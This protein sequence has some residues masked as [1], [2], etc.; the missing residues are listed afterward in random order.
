MTL[1]DYADPEVVVGGELVSGGWL[2]GESAIHFVGRDEGSGLRQIEVRING[3][4][5]GVESLG[6]CEGLI[7]GTD[8]AGSVRPCEPEIPAAEFRLS[9]AAGPFHEGSNLVDVCGLDFAGNE[10]CRS[11]QVL[12][13]NVAPSLS[14]TAAQDSEDPE[15]I[16]AVVADQHSGVSTGE[17]AYRREGGTLWQPLE[18]T[19]QGGALRARVDSTASPPATYE[20]RAIATDLAGNRAETTR[21]TDGLEM[22]LTFPL[23]KG[24]DLNAAI[25]P[26]GAERVT[27]PYGKRSRVSGVLR[28]IAGGPIP[29]Q[30]VV[31]REYFGEGALIRD[32][33][34]TVQTDSRGR[35]TSKLPAGPSRRVTAHYAG[36]QRYLSGTSLGGQLAVRTKAS[37]RTSKSRVPEGGRVIFRGKLGRLGARIPPGGKLL[38]LQ[39]KQDKHTYQTVGQG[40]RSSPSG[41][42]RVPYRFGRFYQYDVRFKFRVKVAREADWPYKAPVRSRGRT[43]T[44]LDR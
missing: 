8:L 34:T 25:E 29:D 40:F 30:D 5:S 35:W 36:T 42:Y 15:L 7:T 19:V 44:V 4:E 14:F 24:V 21:R 43:V 1:A 10:T 28:E 11:H 26:G 20:F 32:R 39:V 18:T 22:R 27:V 17:I 3:S 6:L 37:L 9:T 33:L 2:R 41:R 23:K 38:E 12:V 13:D 16:Q 31:V